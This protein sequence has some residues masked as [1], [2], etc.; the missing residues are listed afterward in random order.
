M[1][2]NIIPS[3]AAIIAG[4]VCGAWLMHANPIIGLVAGPF[5]IVCGLLGG[6]I[7]KPKGER[8]ITADEAV[9]VAN[10]V[11]KVVP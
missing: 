3:F 9:K 10:E 7:L 2:R 1:N 11:K 8:I 5:V 4:I 6:W